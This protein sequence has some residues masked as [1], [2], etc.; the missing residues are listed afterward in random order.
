LNKYYGIDQAEATALNI[1]AKRINSE[2]SNK[3]L[4]SVHKKVLKQYPYLSDV[5]ESML[6]TDLRLP[7]SPIVYANDYFEKMTLYPKEY[8]IGRNCRFLQGKHTSKATVQIIREA[9]STHKP[10]NVEILN[11]RKDGTPFWNN[12]MMLPVFSKKACNYFVAVQK[13]I[14]FL[15]RSR[16]VQIWTPPEVSMFLEERGLHEAAL[17]FLNE[18]VDGDVFL[19][20]N[21]ADLFRMGI[22]TRKDVADVM[23]V[24]GEVKKNNG[25]VGGDRA[26]T[27]GMPKSV[28]S[29]D[30][31][32]SIPVNIDKPEQLKFWSLEEDRQVVCFKVYCQDSIEVVLCKSPVL[33]LDLK[34]RIVQMKHM[35][36]CELKGVDAV[37]KE[38]LLQEQ[39]DLDR[40][41]TQEGTIRLTARES[42][43]DLFAFSSFMAEAANPTLLL[44][45][46]VQH[47]QAPR[48]APRSLEADT[49]RGSRLLK[50]DP[51]VAAE[52]KRV[53]PAPA[54]QVVFSNRSLDQLVSA[55]AG[56]LTGRPSADLLPYL[57]FGQEKYSAL[58]ETYM[59]PFHHMRQARKRNAERSVAYEWVAQ[60]G[61]KATCSISYLPGDLIMVQVNMMGGKATGPAT[62]RHH[63]EAP[64]DSAGA[65]RPDGVQSTSQEDPSGAAD[66]RGSQQD[67]APSSAAVDKAESSDAEE[68][69]GKGTLDESVE[70]VGEQGP[71]V[72][73]EILDLCEALLFQEGSSD[74]LVSDFLH[75]YKMMHLS[76]A[77]LLGIL[78]NIY[79]FYHRLDNPPRFVD[80]R[81]AHFVSLW[82]DHSPRDIY[83]SGI[84]RALINFSQKI[85]P[86]TAGKSNSLK[87]KLLRLKKQAKKAASVPTAWT[88]VSIPENIVLKNFLSSGFALGPEF[89]QTITA[90]QWCFFSRVQP[91]EFVDLA[92][93]AE[94]ARIKAPNLHALARF[95]NQL[96]FLLAQRLLSLHAGATVGNPGIPLMDSAKALT[97]LGAAA[98]SPGLS[99]DENKRLLAKGL[100][101]LIG[102]AQQ[103]H[104]M[105]NFEGC[106]AVVTT[107]NMACLSR[108][109]PAWDLVSPS[110]MKMFHQLDQLMSPLKDFGNYRRRL[111]EVLSQEKRGLVIPHIPSI[112]K[113]VFFA[114]EA[115]KQKERVDKELVAQLGAAFRLIST[116]Q[117]VPQKARLVVKDE[118]V[119][120]FLCL[121]DFEPSEDLLWQLSTS[122]VESTVEC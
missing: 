104:D 95:H 76:P 86:P 47:E 113:D 45:R 90:V 107:L 38:V 14:S 120:H 89:A 78:H 52:G 102:L 50:M 67:C 111:K 109:I 88:G 97:D 1:S 103:L 20:L 83:D 81:L 15:K 30:E 99:S 16:T 35:G 57:R 54:Y 75:M 74:D 105:N 11:Y 56:V 80:T 5:Y 65:V 21:E 114:Y 94:H 13:N 37:G 31:V 46:G 29:D 9:V 108:L 17:L 51:T 61:I 25:Q 72:P 42:S 58:V 2:I 53:A 98:A 68:G 24:I 66:Q 7:D 22:F 19:A 27:A 71:E 28:S 96:S 3:K 48:H 70:S 69:E 44:S 93:Q 40:L 91:D 77:A 4:A 23:G 12:F 116:L 117:C 59:L 36:N 118:I 60:V 26:D 82:V 55:P 64:A 121:L 8:I 79:T 85:L 112:L 110:F 43:M 119:F 62:A 87:L 32:E 63:H 18:E 49:A 34:N 41:L 115:N 92:W 39:D 6:I 100:E 122:I 84:F 101:F 33:L 106:S 73:Q 10:L